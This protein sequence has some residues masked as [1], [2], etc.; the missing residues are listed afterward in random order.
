M[1]LLEETGKLVKWKMGI[2][3]KMDTRTLVDQLSILEAEVVRLQKEELEYKNKNR[4]L[5]AGADSDCSMVKTKLAELWLQTDGMLAS[6][7]KKAA[8]QADKEAW[9][10]QQRTTN[11]ELVTLITGQQKV[12]ASIESFRLEIET[13]KKRVETTLAVIRLKTAQIEFL[14]RSY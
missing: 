5:I 11:T 2:L 14:G 1:R 13:A 9:L 12:L 6:D 10:R 8:T 3:E 7:G 4:G